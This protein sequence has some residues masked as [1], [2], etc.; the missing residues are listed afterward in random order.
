[1]KKFILLTIATVLCFSLFG[2]VKKPTLM[3]TPSFVWCYKNGY[4]LRYDNMGTME[5]IADYRTAIRTSNDLT[6]VISKINILMTDRGFPLKDLS[7]TINSI[8]RNQAMMRAMQSNASGSAIAESPVDV[9]KRQANADILLEL[10]WTVNTSGSR[11]TIT[12]NLRGLDA[13]TGK[14]IAGAQG[15]GA[16]SSTVDL[17]NLL[18]E[19]VLLHIDNFT[20][21]LQ[22]HFD[23]LFENG[24]EVIVDVLVFDNP[25]GLNLET[26]F[27]G[28]ELS[29]IIDDWMALNTVNNRFSK[30]DASDNFI[31]FE[32]VRIP[33]FRPNGMPMDTEFFVR[34]L[35]RFLR[36][37][38]YNISSKLATRGLGRCSL[39]L[40]EK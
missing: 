23:D 26:E 7:A 3:V 19:A 24:R 28:Y 22:A 15:T 31:F 18:E 30:S 10:D 33:L 35:S 8:E 20:D 9:L 13:Y 5:D 29:E 25:E 17:P 27:D 21:Q 36:D 4:I 39:I 32:Q 12:W 38:P 37:E 2:Q 34:E 16:P 6:N 40:G 1:M 11:R 14:Q